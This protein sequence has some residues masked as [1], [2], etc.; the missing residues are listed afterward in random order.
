M[1]GSSARS[2]PIQRSSRGDRPRLQPHTAR[3]AT[4]LA[5]AGQLMAQGGGLSL[6]RLT[7]VPT[8][9]P[10]IADDQLAVALARWLADPTGLTAARAGAR[11]RAEDAYDIRK[12]AD[13]LWD[14]YH[15]VLT[16]DAAPRRSA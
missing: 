2:R 8:T 12:L 13:Q 9:H 6:P 5:S 7:N 15:C 3:G 14:E 4:R 11:R 16:E 1:P 10:M